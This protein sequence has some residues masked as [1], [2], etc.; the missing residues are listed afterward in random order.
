MQELACR[1]VADDDDRQHPYEDDAG[2]ALEGLPR[3]ARE[4]HERE[5]AALDALR[6]R[7]PEGERHRHHE[8][9]VVDDDPAGDHAGIEG[10]ARDPEQTAQ[11]DRRVN[12]GRGDDRLRRAVQLELAGRRHEEGVPG[13]GEDEVEEA[14]AHVAPH[15]ED[16]APEEPHQEALDQHR[17]PNEKQHLVLA[18][19]GDRLGVAVDHE[20]HD[21]V[22]RDPEQLHGRPDEEVAP[23]HGRPHERILRAREPDPQVVGEGVHRGLGQPPA[24]VWWRRPRSHTASARHTRMMAQM[25][26]IAS[27]WT[28]KS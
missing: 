23:E 24:A 8:R 1:S 17:G 6:A 12:V 21:D 22:H 3:Q 16:A 26:W 15:L 19:A 20:H 4:L 10:H 11:L 18:P 13:L 14:A 5:V 7:D 27:P 2:D 25:A 9:A 28:A